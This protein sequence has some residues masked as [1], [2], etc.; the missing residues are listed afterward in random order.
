[1]RITGEALVWVVLI[2]CIASAQRWEY[3]FNE[4]ITQ[5]YTLET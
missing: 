2:S 4:S 5:D 1:M 3:H